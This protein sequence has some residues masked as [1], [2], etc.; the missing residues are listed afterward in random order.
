MDEVKTLARLS[1][2]I[3][4]LRT[5]MGVSQ[6]SFADSISMHRAQYSKI[7]RGEINVTILT[8]RR[9]AKGLGTTA[10]DLLDQAKI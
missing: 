6:E 7:E 9:I 3:L 2:A 10:A 4:Q 8:L 1:K 5:A